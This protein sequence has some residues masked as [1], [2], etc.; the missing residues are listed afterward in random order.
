MCTHIPKK[1]FSSLAHEKLFLVK[2]VF[3]AH[4]AVGRKIFF[5]LLWQFFFI[6]KKVA[7]RALLNTE[8]KITAP[9]SKIEKNYIWGKLNL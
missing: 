2:N 7:Q 3:Y 5:T 4:C 9:K 1:T 8:K 6:N